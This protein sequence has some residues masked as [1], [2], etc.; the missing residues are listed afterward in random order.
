MPVVDKQWEKIIE[1]QS[2]L[3]K[4]KKNPLFEII[5]FLYCGNSLALGGSEHVS[6]TGK[7]MI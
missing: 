5:A 3:P 2:T 6:Y 4:K 7:P 1:I